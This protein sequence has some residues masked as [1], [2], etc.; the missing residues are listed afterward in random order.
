MSSSNN[1]SGPRGTGTGKGSTAAKKGNS[2]KSPNTTASSKTKK[3][4]L[5][6]KITASDGFTKINGVVDFDEFITRYNE[7]DAMC[8]RM[9]KNCDTCGLPNKFAD[10]VLVL[11]EY[12]ERIEGTTVWTNENLLM[13]A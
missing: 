1:R 8:T 11:R 13:Q 2:S 3:S 6:P 10:L 12:I 9:K 5:P 4:K 7:L